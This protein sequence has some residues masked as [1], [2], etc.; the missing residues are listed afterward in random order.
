MADSF[1]TFQKFSD[2]NLAKNAGRVLK[3]HDIQYEIETSGNNF[4]PSFAFN[5]FD[6]EIRIKIKQ[7]DFANA[8]NA[9]EEFYSE[10]LENVESGYYLFDYSDTEL[11]DIVAKPDEWG[12]FDYLLA[13][14]ILK[15]RG[16]EIKPDEIEKLKENRLKSLYDPAAA[17]RMLILIG[18]TAAIFGGILGLVIGLVI[19]SNKKTLPNG[20]T[21]Y[22]HTDKDRKNGKIIVVVSVISILF[23]LFTYSWL[24]KY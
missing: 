24:L 16:L 21:I 18:Y 6:A 23:W 9:L 13:I 8:R 11:K 20:Q 12:Y 3:Q 15:D 17:S 14:K 22:I 10:T 7:E 4:D 19:F 2:L 1:L 5:S